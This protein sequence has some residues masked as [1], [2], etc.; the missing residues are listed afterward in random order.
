VPLHKPGGSPGFLFPNRHLVLGQS[1][2]KLFCDYNFGSLQHFES[3]TLAE[4]LFMRQTTKS[5][6]TSRTTLI[7]LIAIAVLYFI[8]FIFPNSAASDD[9]RMVEIFEPDE[10]YPMPYLLEMIQPADSLG[11]AIRNFFDYEYYFYGFPH[12]A[13]SALVILP[14]RLLTELEQ[15]VSLV[16]VLLRQLVSLLPLLAANL[17]LVHMQIGIKQHRIK[18]IF[19]FLFLLA[20]PAVVQNNFWWHPDG[21]AA[22]FIVLTIFFLSRDDLNF[23][24]DFYLAAAACAAATGTKTIGLFFFLTIPL[25]ILWG[26][27]IKKIN[28]KQAFLAGLGFVAILVIGIVITNPQL[29]FPTPRRGYIFT[30]KT[31]SLFVSS[32]FEV[33]YPKGLSA[34]APDLTKYF[35]S[36]VFLVIA[37][38]APVIGIIKDRRRLLHFLIL[39]WSVPLSIY[40]IFFTIFKFQYFLPAALPLISSIAVFIPDLGKL[41]QN[42]TSRSVKKIAGAALG[43]VAFLVILFQFVSNLGWD[44]STYTARLH[45]AETSPSLQFYQKVEENLAPLIGVELLAYRDVRLYVPNASAWDTFAEFKLLDYGTFQETNPEVILLMQQR[46]RDYL[47][48][49]VAGIEPGQLEISRI[50]YRDADQGSLEGYTL[51]FRDDF[52]LAFVRDD[53]YREYFE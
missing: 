48:P 22:L 42:L 5:L 11:Q 41:K 18:A 25:Y 38:L 53:I 45:R 27:R 43:A 17:L 16:M 2:T 31:Q 6:N 40:V 36:F 15:H 14:V 51:V 9:M 7:L 26:W 50:F 4:R 39:T 10:A 1:K 8:I 19:L 12:F 29:L 20:V 34:A 35:G 23:G 46:L 3:I 30:L 28:L 21:L 13:Y 33:F 47:N 44:I 32:G 52:G 24:R 37:L 49:A